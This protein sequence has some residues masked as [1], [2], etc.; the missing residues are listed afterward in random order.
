MISGR[1]FGLAILALGIVLLVF[2]HNATEA[3][4]E[5]LSETFTGNYTDRTTWMIIAG[6]V[7]VC[8]GGLLAL[9]GTGP[10]R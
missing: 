5:R 1:I 9:I 2:G 3:P 6:I 8:G 10:T 7:A 4:L